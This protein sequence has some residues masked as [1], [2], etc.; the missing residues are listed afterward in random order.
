MIF[1][2]AFL[3]LLIKMLLCTFMHEP[4]VLSYWG[5]WCDECVKSFSTFRVPENSYATGQTGSHEKSMPLM[6]FTW[7]TQVCGVGNPRGGLMT[8][9]RSE[10]SKG[11]GAGYL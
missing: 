9:K 1:K 7:A 11:S 6:L 8:L 4:V 5:Y 10:G 2:K 3:S